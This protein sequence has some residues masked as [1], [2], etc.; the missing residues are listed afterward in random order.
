MGT[1]DIYINE[2][3]SP[4]LQYLGI[5]YDIVYDVD[6]LKHPGLLEGYKVLYLPRGQP[7]LTQDAEVS[8]LLSKA[9]SKIIIDENVG[10]SL[11]N[12]QAALAQAYDLNPDGWLD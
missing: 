7:Q 2:T 1:R 8:A 4:M 12:R 10:D 6:L 9:K 11:E 3:I 5:H